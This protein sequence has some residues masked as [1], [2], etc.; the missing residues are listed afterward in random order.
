[1]W[2]LNSLQLTC[3]F[4]YH[5]CDPVCFSDCHNKRSSRCGGRSQVRYF[6]GD[7]I[8]SRSDLVSSSLFFRT[9]ATFLLFPLFMLLG[10]CF[11]SML[12]SF[13]TPWFASQFFRKCTLWNYHV[14]IWMSIVIKVSDINFSNKAWS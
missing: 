11:P 9:N 5:I 7:N 6:H 14:I 3:G 12:Q 1:M 10:H 13:R 2:T 8:F 4:H